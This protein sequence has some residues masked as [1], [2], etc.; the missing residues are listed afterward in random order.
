MMGHAQRT[1]GAPIVLVVGGGLA[2]M[3]AALAARSAGAD[4]S[5]LSLGP[6]GRSGNTLVAGGIS[7]ATEDA[8]NSPE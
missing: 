4:V 7:S 2:G 1:H 8:K 6:A 5:L 3:T